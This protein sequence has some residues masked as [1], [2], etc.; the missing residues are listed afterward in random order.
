MRLLIP[1]LLF[2]ALALVGCSQAHAQTHTLTDDTTG[3][4]VSVEGDYLIEAETPQGLYTATIGIKGRNG[5]PFISEPTKVPICTASF[6]PMPEAAALTQAE[7][8]ALSP[9]WSAEVEKSLAAQV[10]FEAREPFEFKGV[11]GYKFVLSP[12]DTFSAQMRIVLYVMQ[13]PKGRT[14]LNCSGSATTLAEA[15]P[16]YEL[17]RDGLTLP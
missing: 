13:T 16:T 12:S 2:S 6:Q 1:V 10:R 15:M 8:N 4:A 5:H 11:S 14:V 9:Q 17:M 3:L 7:L